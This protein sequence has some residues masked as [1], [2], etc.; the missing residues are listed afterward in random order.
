MTP[1]SHIRQLPAELGLN[2]FLSLDSLSDVVHLAATSKHFCDVWKVHSRAISTAL[3][4][5]DVPLYDQAEEL[6]TALLQPKNGDVAQIEEPQKACPSNSAVDMAKLVLFLARAATIQMKQFKWEGP[7]ILLWKAYL[8][9]I[10]DVRLPDFTEVYWPE[11][12][13]FQ[14]NAY[15]L[16]LSTYYQLWLLA[17]IPRDAAKEHWDS[18]S[19]YQRADLAAFARSWVISPMVVD[20]FTHQDDFD[21]YWNPLLDRLYPIFAKDLGWALLCH[22]DPDRPRWDHRQR[23]QFA[24]GLEYLG[25]TKDVSSYERDICRYK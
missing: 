3:L 15:K 18:L 20:I 22:R 14:D 6:A 16:F 1:T 5:H 13:K 8:P 21:E 12:Y 25:G 10:P 24:V 9:N 19:A 17:V 2:V 7:D 11:C 4:S 23:D